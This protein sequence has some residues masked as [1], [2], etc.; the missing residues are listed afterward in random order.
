MQPT[1]LPSSA[2][3]L[4]LAALL[5]GDFAAATMTLFTNDVDPGEGAVVGDFTAAT[6]TTS[7]PAAITTWGAPYLTPEGYAEAIGTEHQ[8]AWTAGAAE[9]VFGI[10][11]KSAGMGTPLLAY[12]RLIA[13]KPMQAVGNALAIVPKLRLGP[14]GFG[15][16]IQV[17]L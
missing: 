5:A 17:S 11:I 12:A 6:F 2:L 7:T 3:L 4:E 9:N 8:W 13:P 16:S 14:A 15:A 10:L 1:V